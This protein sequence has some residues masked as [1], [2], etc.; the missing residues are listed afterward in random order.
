VGVGR[1]HGVET[2]RLHER[3]EGEHCAVFYDARKWQVCKQATFWLSDTPDVAASMTW[4]N[5]LPRI[6][7]WAIFEA[8]AGGSEFAV[9]NTHFHWGE[10]VV[11]NST[12]LVLDTMRVLASGLPTILVGDFNLPPDSPTYRAF[13]DQDR[14]GLVDCWRACGHS[15]EK[16]E[17]V[18]GFSGKG[19][20][21]LDWLLVSKR[22]E[23]RSVERIAFNRA[24]RYPSDHFPVR[25]EL[26]L[27][28]SASVCT[29]A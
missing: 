23:T 27:R 22:F 7:T 15:E 17:T 2:D 5:D 14:G 6:A 18:H 21:R 25:A 12:A 24:G 3:K 1:Y 13:T 28:G 9:F 20:R 10:L 4:G 29:G 8:R 16:G 19:R 26:C 11:Q